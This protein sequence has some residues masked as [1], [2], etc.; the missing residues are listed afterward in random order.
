MAHLKKKHITDKYLDDLPSYLEKYG[1]NTAVLIEVGSFYNIY[2]VDNNKEKIGN[3]DKI[4]DILDIQ[5]TRVN[6]KASPGNSRTN[7]QMAGFPNHSLD[8][9][10]Q[11]LSNNNF[12]TVII[13]QYDSESKKG[14]KE[15]KVDRIVSPSTFIDNKCVKDQSNILL[16]IY[17]KYVK[18]DEIAI[19]YIDLT[20]GKNECY[21]IFNQSETL[22][23]KIDKII[24]SLSPMEIIIYTDNCEFKDEDEVKIKFNL[25]TK[26]ILV[27]IYINNI[28]K[29]IYKLSYQ[30]SFLNEIFDKCGTLTPIEYIGLERF[31]VN[32]ICYI[33]LLR[34]AKEHDDM[35]IKKIN[36]PKIINDDNI[37]EISSNCISQLNLLPNTQLEKDSPSKLSSVLN[38]LDET[39][40]PMGKRLFKHRL[41]TPIV[42]IESL[43][44]RYDEVEKFI[45]MSKKSKSTS[46]RWELYEEHLNEIRDLER[47]HRKIFFKKL[48]PSEFEELI[49]SYEKVDKLLKLND[50]LFKE[51]NQ[52]KPCSKFINNGTITKFYEY[53]KFYESKINSDTIGRYDESSEELLTIFKDGVFPEIDILYDKIDKQWKKIKSVQKELAESIFNENDNQKLKLNHVK[54]SGMYYFS[55]TI[56][57]SKLITSDIINK[58]SLRLEKMASA[59]KVHSSIIDNCSLAIYNYKDKIRKLNKD[60]FIIFLEDI[61]DKYE[62]TLKNISQYIALLDIYKSI[63]K[64]SVLNNYTRPILKQNDRSYFDIKGAR[65]P[66]I[67]K[68]NEA[69][70][71]VQN[72][73]SINENIKHILLYGLNYAG[74]SSLL[75]T[76]GTIIIMAQMGFYVPAS[77]FELCPFKNMITKIAIQDNIYKNQS[78]FTSELSELKNMLSFG[79]KHSLILADELCNGS[80]YNSSVSLVTATILKLINKDVNFIFTTHFHSLVTIPSIKNIIKLHKLFIYH[81]STQIDYKNGSVIFDRLLK[82]GQGSDTYGIEIASFFNVGDDD[83]IE[84]AYETRKFLLGDEEKIEKFKGKKEEVK[85]KSKK[86]KIPSTVRNSVWNIY[87]GDDKK[88]GVCFCCSTE[89]ISTANFH[90]GHVIS[91][92]YGGEVKINNLRPICGQCNLSMGTKNMLEF[93]REYGFDE[94]NLKESEKS[95]LKENKKKKV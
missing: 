52:V 44:E 56:T 85:K 14:K 58:Y 50:E 17:I 18:K 21:I 66:L 48:K 1:P 75:R 6:N 33:L 55:V 45:N 62:I 9:Y 76:I 37:L 25:H 7:P 74:K 4:C 57:T 65:H 46:T 28:D 34:F 93:M 11:K 43:N 38:L 31:P 3:I 77:Y 71:Y 41:L 20:T 47:L 70:P 60:K 87:I 10:L 22:Y 5:K 15:R 95:D 90:C 13:N 69:T 64:V 54:K 51:N 2:G 59:Y 53:I 30:N 84:N 86:E 68:I 80:E 40:T 27:H 19:N 26:K 63:A 23:S 92:K 73:L 39:S 88:I 36:K 24:D 29:D 35:I 83:F 8:D 79:S 49:S 89:Q 81:M 12:T 72:D 42:N 82:E 61:T 67:E 32:I 94:S 91:E 78:L 16:C